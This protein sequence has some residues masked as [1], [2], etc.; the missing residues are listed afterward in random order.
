MPKTVA[1]TPGCENCP[2]QRLFP[3]NNFVPA[4]L[5]ENSTRLCVGEA[6]G[7]NEQTQGEPFVGSSG[8]WLFGR[9]GENGKKSGGLYRAAGI[10]PATISK[11]NV[12]GCRPPDNNFPTDASARAYISKE[13]AEASLAQCW[14]SHVEPVLKSRNWSRIDCFGDKAL[15]ALTGQSGIMRWRGSPLAVPA[16]GPEPLTVPTLHPSYIARDQSMLPAVVSDL[17]KSLALAPEHYNVQPTLDDVRA[18]TATE[19][20]FDIEC[21][22]DTGKITMVG[23]SEKP[24]YAMC[25]PFSGAYIAELK[26]IFENAEVLY[27]QNGIAFDIPRLFPHLGLEWRP[28]T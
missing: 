23:L 17:A 10:D 3:Q 28:S 12:L 4:F 20:S 26:R 2:M 6:P 18:F 7:E 9:E 1:E 15:T 11:L 14:R 25:V 5:V 27:C 16:C 13:E 21:T 24:F 19:F 8:N 22:R